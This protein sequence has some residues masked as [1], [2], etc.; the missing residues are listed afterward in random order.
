M[1]VRSRGFTLL[2]LIVAF[3]ILVLFVLPMLEIIAA[4]RIRAVRYTRDRVVRDLAQRKL[5]ERIYYLETMDAGTFELE[6]HPEW[7]WEI[8]RPEIV[9]QG[10][11]ILL[12]YTIRVM[13]PQAAAGAGTVAE[14]GEAKPA[15]EM[16]SW[17]FPSQ[18][19]LDEQSALEAQGYDTGL[20]GSGTGGYRGY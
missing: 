12:Q 15:F 19:W 16:S 7:N 14:G 3:T 18:E 13:T 10:E 8:D 1:K 2:E 5:F 17:T 6:G 11:Q 9:S 20:Y 4:A